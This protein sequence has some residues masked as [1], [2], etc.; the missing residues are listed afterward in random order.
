VGRL[1]DC[2]T[3]PL[4]KPSTAAGEAG[5][6]ALLDDPAG[7]LLGLDFDGVLAPIVEDPSRSRAH[8][9]V[10]GALERLGRHLG[11]IAVVTGRPAAVA[12][13]Y[14]GLDRSEALR[15]VVVFGHYGVERWDSES[16]R[17]SAPPVHEGVPAVRSA[18]PGVLRQ[19]S[20]DGEVHIEDKGRSVA[21]HTRRAHQPEAA[22]VRLAPALEDLALRHGLVLEPGRLVIELRPPGMD[23]GQALRRHAADRGARSVAYIGDDL[24]DL[25]AFAAIDLLRTEGLS[26]LKVCSGSVEVEGLAEQAD[27]VVDGPPGVVDLLEAWADE[28]DA[29]R[30]AA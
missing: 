19:L 4:P 15:G 24:G 9:G 2:R 30:P 1:L 6:A 16:G 25:P 7:V 26:G 13:D 27:L 10:V 5:L 21:V 22:L 17:V 29:R 18:L 23:K 3:V 12:V 20:L 11:A 14:S 28:L 8:P